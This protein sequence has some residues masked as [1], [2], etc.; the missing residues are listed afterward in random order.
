M[1]I[2]FSKRTST[3][4]HMF[5]RLNLNTSPINHAQTG[6]RYLGTCSRT[7]QRPCRHLSP[8][9][10]ANNCIIAR[11]LYHGTLRSHR[12]VTLNRSYFNEGAQRYNI[13][14]KKMQKRRNNS[15][16]RRQY[17]RHFAAQRTHPTSARATVCQHSGT[18]Q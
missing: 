16:S 14:K 7:L 17:A 5:G 2:A 12:Q 4:V 8:S 18:T 3:V 15:N 1:V 11:S 9:K 6:K 13:T 10:E